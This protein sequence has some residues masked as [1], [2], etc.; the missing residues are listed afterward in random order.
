MDSH[1]AVLPCHAQCPVQELVIDDEINRTFRHGLLVQGHAHHHGVPGLIKVAV[2]A[3]CESPAPD[4]ARTAETSIEILG[5]DA[6]KG[7]GQVVA[8]TA[9]AGNDGTGRR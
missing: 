1:P 2:L 3:Y 7:C 4:K 8:D 5:I 6:I 9:G